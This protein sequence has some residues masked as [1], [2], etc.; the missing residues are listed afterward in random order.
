[1]DK[2]WLFKVPDNDG[3]YYAPFIAEVVEDNTDSRYIKLKAD[4]NTYILEYDIE[5]KLINGWMHYSDKG[6]MIY[7]L[8]EMLEVQEKFALDILHTNPEFFI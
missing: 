1:M 7:D 3:V 4:N 6:D 2:L 8:R 5:D